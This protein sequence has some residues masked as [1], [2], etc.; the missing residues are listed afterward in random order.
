MTTLSWNSQG[1]GPPRKVRFLTDVIRQERPNF[2]FLGE[3][4][5][6]KDKIE[7]LRMK[8]GFEGMVVVDPQ[9][10]SG[11]LAFLWCDS[12]QEKL[13]SL[14][15]N[16]IDVE[17]TVE[18][19]G[20]WRITGMYGEPERSNRRKTWDLLRNLARDS[21]LPWCTIGDLNN[22]TSQQD[23]QGGEPYPTWLIDGFNE[24]LIDA[25]LMDMEL[26]EHQFTWE[27][28]RGKQDWTEVRLDRAVIT[29]EWQNLFPMANLFNLEGSNSDHSPVFLVPKK[30]DIGSGPSDFKFE[31]AWLLEPM[32]QQLVSAYWKED[33]N[34]DI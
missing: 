4:I 22:V 23:K 9:G 3:T 15:Q 30:R 6:K 25:G 33:E 11:G 14:S 13:M 27:R 31:N 34:I 12:D 18:G 26:V 19:M 5:C 32:C 24:A 21:N 10:R 1:I 17:V 28:G 20:V 29:Q 16:H 7:F 2:V 8:L